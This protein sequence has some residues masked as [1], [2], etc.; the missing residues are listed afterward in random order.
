MSRQKWTFSKGHVIFQSQHV[1]GDI[2]IFLRFARGNRISWTNVFPPQKKKK[3]TTRK[4]GSFC[5]TK[6]PPKAHQHLKADGSHEHHL[7][8]GFPGFPP[9]WLRKFLGGIPRIPKKTKQP[10]PQDPWDWY[11][12]VNNIYICL[13]T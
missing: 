9:G 2:R 6:F 7:I 12:Y 13:P 11:L 5:S 4:S 3:T 10:N 8:P 1:S